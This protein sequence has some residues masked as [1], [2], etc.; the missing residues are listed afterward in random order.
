MVF[1]TLLKLPWIRTPKLRWTPLKS[2]LLGGWQSSS[3]AE[4]LL[5]PPS[6]LA[7]STKFFSHHPT[8]CPHQRFIPHPLNRNFHIK[9]NKNLICNILNLIL[10]SLYT[11]FMPI[12]I[13]I[14]VQ[15]LR[16]VAFSFKKIRMVKITPQKNST[17]SLSNFPIPH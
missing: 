12:L 15:Y 6:R 3:I 11:Q 16:N 4:N 1:G 7:H 2:S 8:R 14:N 13:L 5:I 9:T 17:P 10:Y